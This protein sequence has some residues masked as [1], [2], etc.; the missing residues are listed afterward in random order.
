M[1]KNE[2]KYR[3]FNKKKRQ[4]S[5]IELF[6]KNKSPRSLIQVKRSSFTSADDEKVIGS[7]EH[8]PDKS[9]KPSASDKVGLFIDHSIILTFHST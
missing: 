4:A 9:S 8:D 1:S 2:Q 6:N 5:I 3:V 7:R